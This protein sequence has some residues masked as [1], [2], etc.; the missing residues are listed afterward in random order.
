MIRIYKTKETHKRVP[1]FDGMSIIEKFAIIVL[2]CMLCFMAYTAVE[3]I[4]GF[5]WWLNLIISIGIVTLV[6]ILIYALVSWFT[7]GDW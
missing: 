2:P 3:S 1:L 7:G 5:I 6:I 4:F